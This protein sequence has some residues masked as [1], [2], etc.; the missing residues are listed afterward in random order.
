M[1]SLTVL[2]ASY[3]ELHTT[4]IRI[5]LL[6]QKKVQQNRGDISF[7][8]RIY[9]IVSLDECGYLVKEK[10]NVGQSLAAKIKLEG[11]ASTFKIITELPKL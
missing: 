8:L 7:G 3:V 5:K 10:I 2:L 6:E 11:A 4:S 9:Q 1:K